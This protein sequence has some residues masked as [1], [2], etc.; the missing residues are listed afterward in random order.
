MREMR[1]DIIIHNHYLYMSLK[2]S[3]FLISSILCCLPVYS[4]SSYIY[5]I[6]SDLQASNCLK[7]YAHSIYGLDLRQD[8][9]LHPSRL[10]LYSATWCNN[11]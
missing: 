8:M 2:L 9:Y 5:F 7:N 6:Y 3:V 11:T 1:D 4:K 10:H